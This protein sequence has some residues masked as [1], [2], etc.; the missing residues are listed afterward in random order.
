M[1]GNNI[2]T[3][4]DLRFENY[5]VQEG[6]KNFIYEP[7]KTK[8][9]QTKN[10]DYLVKRGKSALVEVKEIESIPLDHVRGVGSMDAMGVAKIIRKKIYE[11]SKQLKP[12]IKKVNYCIILF[13]KSKGF[14]LNIRDVEWAMYGDPIIRIPI[15]TEKGAPRGKPEFDFK[16][17]GAMRKNNPQTK[18][19]YFPSAYISAVGIINEV[20]GYDFFMSKLY[21]KY[22]SPYNKNTLPREEIKRAFKEIKLIK[23][24]YEHTIPDVYQKNKKKSIFSL[25]IIANALSNQ[26]LPKSFFLGQFN[27]Y[28]IHRV[29][30]N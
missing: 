16:V 8:S 29:V 13:G 28:K 21:E 4:I 3:A 26:P 9:K 20:N 2:K 6:I 18:Q 11:A 25:K 30:R 10:P 27:S 22:M 12:Y 15:N 7:F 17:M 24:K 5:L 1:L 23:K 14:N 19:M